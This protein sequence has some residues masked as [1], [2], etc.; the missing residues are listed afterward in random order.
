MQQGGQD[1]ARRAF[2]QALALYESLMRRNPGDVRSRV[3]SVV[4]RWRLAG[5]DAGKGRGYL[6][7]A[8][9]ILKP[10]AEA[11]H[12]DAGRLRWISLMEGQL[13]AMGT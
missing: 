11:N 7:A 10:L 13:A 9:A 8:L 12:L 3:F 5:L 2:E 6:R 4:P 1:E